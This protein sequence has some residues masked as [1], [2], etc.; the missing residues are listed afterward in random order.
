MSMSVYKNFLQQ[1]LPYLPP[2]Q[3]QQP[4]QPP[5]LLQPPEPL[6]QQQFQ[7]LALFLLLIIQLQ[8]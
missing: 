4:L 1:R 7:L 5:Q 8:I 6:Q 3:L 2:P